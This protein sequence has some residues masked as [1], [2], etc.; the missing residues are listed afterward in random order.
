MRALR[1]LLI[2]S[3]VHEQRQTYMQPDAD[4]VVGFLQFWKGMEDM[5]I[6]Q[7]MKRTSIFHLFPSFFFQRV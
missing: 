6:E 3:R 2:R 7:K 5:T 4:G 1:V